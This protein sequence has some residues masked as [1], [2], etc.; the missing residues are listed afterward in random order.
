MRQL[1]VA[2]LCQ[3]ALAAAA[4]AQSVNVT[5]A[6]PPTEPA[7]PTNDLPVSARVHVL[8]CSRIPIAVEKVGMVVNLRYVNDPCPV[9]IPSDA[10]VP[11]GTLFLAGTYTLRVLEVSDPAHPRLDDEATVVVTPV[12]CPP[13]PLSPQILQLCLHDARFS[14]FA[15]WSGL[16]TGAAHPIKLSSDS[17]AMW[18]FTADNPELMV[19]VLDAC[20][21]NGHFWLFAAGLTDVEVFIDVRDNLTG[22]Q[23]HYHNPRGVPFQPI[24]DTIAFACP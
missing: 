17:G 20:G 1:L 12:I 5:L 3:L 16:P 19:K 24:N 13:H 22:A 6:D 9:P 2:C 23:R 7:L 4:L 10:T 14:V 18:F 8:A 21:Y 15:I 11:L